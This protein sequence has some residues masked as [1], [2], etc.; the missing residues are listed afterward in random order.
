LYKPI[1]GSAYIIGALGVLQ[2]DVIAS[3]LEN[4]YRVRANFESVPL[5]SS[6]WITS[7]DEDELE[8]FVK[9]NRVRI[10]R[11]IADQYSFIAQ[12]DWAVGYAEEQYPKVRFHKTK[13]I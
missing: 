10:Y 1:E 11:D 7:E 2:F 12:S 3:R 4:E 8:R 9:E 5:Q 6:R 13:E